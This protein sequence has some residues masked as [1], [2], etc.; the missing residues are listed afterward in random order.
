MKYTLEV[1]AKDL[2]DLELLKKYPKLRTEYCS[3]MNH[4]GYTPAE[5]DYKVSSKLDIE[6]AIMV[7][8]SEP[9]EKEYT[10]EIQSKTI[11]SIEKLIKLGF[12]RL[13]VGYLVNN[14]IDPKLIE[15]IN[16]YANKGIKFTFHRAFERVE[17]KEKAL[18][19]LSKSAVDTILTSFDFRDP[20]VA[21]KYLEWQK[22]YNIT[23]LVGGG[24]KLSDI[25][26]LK[27]IG[28]NSIHLGRTLRFNESWDHPI[29]PELLDEAYK[30]MFD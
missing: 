4:G 14:Q 29:N 1:I 17:D 26:D 10:P 11:E 28:F 22:K 27:K 15:D 6:Q 7:R 23:F 2:K 18:E 3:S 25:K 8:F 16:K 19:I 5:D 24:I 9:F 13:V 21:K 12:K 20:K 30:E